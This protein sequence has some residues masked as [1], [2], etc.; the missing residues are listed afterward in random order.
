MYIDYQYKK[1]DYTNVFTVCTDQT[2]MHCVSY[3]YEQFYPNVARNIAEKNI[4]LNHTFV[5]MC[6]VMIHI[7][8]LY[9]D[10]TKPHS[11]R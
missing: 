6:I 8:K 9:D 1:R 7:Q 5:L 11:F 4:D 3:L 2:S 10:L